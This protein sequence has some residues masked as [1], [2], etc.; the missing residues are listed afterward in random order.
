MSNSGAIT[1]GRVRELKLGMTPEAVRAICGDPL[2]QWDEGILCMKYPGITVT[3]VDGSVNMLIVE[4][5]EI[6]AT[7]SGV[8]VGM[9]FRNL[10][11]LVG[12]VI[13]DDDDGA[14]LWTT[15]DRPGIWYEIARPPT[16][17]EEPLNPPLVS[18]WFNVQDPEKAVVRSIFVM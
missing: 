4:S 1:P 14:M 9:S 6:G 15:S 13:F 18:E 3:A 2:D 8:S 17:G 7:D 11:G 12:S 16:E 5:A 10:E